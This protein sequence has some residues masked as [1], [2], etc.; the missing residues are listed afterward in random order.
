MPRAP[1]P[2][3]T[4]IDLACGCST[5]EGHCIVNVQCVAHAHLVPRKD[6]EAMLAPSR[7]LGQVYGPLDGPL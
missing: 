2:V 3:E 6:R 7:A 1:L 5:S 4:W